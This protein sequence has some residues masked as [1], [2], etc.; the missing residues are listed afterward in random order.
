[1]LPAH[2]HLGPIPPAVLLQRPQH[3]G[4]AAAQ[5]RIPYDLRD[6]AFV[7]I[8][9]WQ[10]AQ[11]LSDTLSVDYLH[12]RLR[13]F[14]QRFCP[15]ARHFRS[16]YYWSFMQVEYALDVVFDRRPPG[17]VYVCPP[18]SRRGL[19][20]RHLP[21]ARSLQTPRVGPRPSG[22]RPPT[23]WAAIDDAVALSSSATTS[24]TRPPRAPA[25]R[26]LAPMALLY[27]LPRGSWPQPRRYLGPLR[28]VLL[29][30]QPSPH[31]PPSSRLAPPR[32]LS[33]VRLVPRAPSP[34]PPRA[35]PP[36]PPVSLCHPPPL[37]PPSLSLPLPSPPPPSLPSPRRG[38][39]T[40]PSNDGRAWAWAATGCCGP[41]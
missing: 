30:S 22:T 13:E 8:A 11:E 20:R 3:V 38:R 41:G 31:L 1:M 40:L 28:C 7:Q 27:A 12:R 17:A 14:C 15:V 32:S 4:D 18:A 21:R 24:P 25:P 6:N 29:A 16:E 39:G 5:K 9:N 37:S 34:S 23:G 33:P 36:P 2:S 35:A 26:W 10:A 19:P